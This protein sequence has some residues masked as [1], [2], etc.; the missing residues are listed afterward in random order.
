MSFSRVFMRCASPCKKQSQLMNN[1]CL[2]NSCNSPF[3]KQQLF[4]SRERT[5]HQLVTGHPPNHGG[6]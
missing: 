1:D 2:T 3:E 5:M 6:N 4:I